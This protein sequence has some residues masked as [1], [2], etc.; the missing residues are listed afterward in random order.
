MPFR[1]RLHIGKMIEWNT[2][3]IVMHVVFHDVE[4]EPPNK[5]WEFDMRRA[6]DCAV[7]LLPLFIGSVPR[8]SVMGVVHEYR[9]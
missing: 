1:K 9:P 2:R 7:A 6:I 8:N 5:A 4:N 3:R